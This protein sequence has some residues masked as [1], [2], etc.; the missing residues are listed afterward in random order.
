MLLYLAALLLFGLTVRGVTSASVA[1]LGPAGRD[2]RG[3]RDRADD[4]GACRTSGRSARTSPTTGSATRSPTGT[5]SGCWPRS[6][7]SSALHMATRARGPRVA[8]VLGAA[9]VPL[10]ATTVY[11]TFSR[12]AILAGVIGTVAYLALARPRG[13]VSGLAAAVPA[14]AIALVVAYHADLLA[15]EHPTIPAAVSQG[16]RVAWVLAACIVGAALDQARLPEARHTGFADA[17]HARPA[18][19]PRRG[20]RSSG[21][22]GGGR[23]GFR[24]ARLGRGG[25][26]TSSSPAHRSAKGPPASDFRQRLYLGQLQRAPG[27]LGR[28]GRSVRGEQSSKERGAGTF[29]LAWERERDYPG[30]V[31]DA[32]GLYPGDPGRAGPGWARPAGHGAGRDSRRTRGADSWQGPNRVR[33]AFLPPPSAGWWPRPSTGTGRCRW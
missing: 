19:G 16:H 32:H 10:L 2:R 27:L 3:L 11:F 9:A 25:S 13:T 8:R 14:T 30:T 15:T 18:D 20:R 28:R 1:G 23:P 24:S 4:A 17:A 22:G 21:R 7:S 12:G 5:R 6:G 29:Q 33:G 31:V 26:T